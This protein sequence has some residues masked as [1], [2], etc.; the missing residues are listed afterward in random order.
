MGYGMTF[1]EVILLSFAGLRGAMGLILGLLVDIGTEEP[2]GLTDEESLNYRKTRTLI[3]FH[4]AG[5]AILTI[6]LNG[7][8]TGLLIN[9]L[10]MGKKSSPLKM[11]L[12]HNLMEQIDDDVDEAID[13]LKENKDYNLVD[14]DIV[15]ASCELKDVKEEI[16]ELR[17]KFKAEAQKKNEKESNE[18]KPTSSKLKDEENGETKL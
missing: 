16:E 11:K 15:R 18:V 7:N 9:W 6:I 5:I 8:T 3:L 1:K 4:M 12:L 2:E 13:H 10:G 14:W 17:Q